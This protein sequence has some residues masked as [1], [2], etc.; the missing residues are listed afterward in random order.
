MLDTTREQLDRYLAERYEARCFYCQ[1][2]GD[3][4][5]DGPHADRCGECK[6]TGRVK[7]WQ[8]PCPCARIEHADGINHYYDL[9]GCKTC[10]LRG[11]GR[12]GEI[13]HQ[14]DCFICKGSGWL[15]GV[16]EADGTVRALRLEDILLA[17]RAKG[18][19]YE[20]DSDSF[21]DGKL[22]ALL[23]GE[24][25]PGEA[26]VCDD[27]PYLAAARALAKV[28]GRRL[29]MAS[30]ILTPA[31]FD[32]NITNLQNTGQDDPEGAVSTWTMLKAHDTALR[33]ERDQALE[34]LRVLSSAVGRH[35]CNRLDKLKAALAHHAV[36]AARKMLEEK[37]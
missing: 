21:G 11:V 30:D 16:R 27:D 33:A 36:V 2:S 17:A 23:Y 12:Y 18:F 5:N 6:G 14:A 25:K 15:P 9:G 1:G 7:P 35:G 24:G 29:L 26:Y 31:Q 34:A 13:R 8:Q 19:H 3:G 37:R 10:W 20:I 22:G 4:H 32:A 28:L